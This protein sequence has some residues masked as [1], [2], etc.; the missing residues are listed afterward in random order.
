MDSNGVGMALLWSSYGGTIGQRPL[1]PSSFISMLF[2]F[3]VKLFQDKSHL[4][5]RR[6]FTFNSLLEYGL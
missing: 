1:M 5:R 3:V 6:H 2:E 4:I